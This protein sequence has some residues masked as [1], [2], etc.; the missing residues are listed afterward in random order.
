M[1]LWNKTT[2]PGTTTL[3]TNSAK[4]TEITEIGHGTSHDLTPKSVLDPHSGGWTF[5]VYYQW[6]TFTGLLW[7]TSTGSASRHLASPDWTR[8]RPKLLAKPDVEETRVRYVEQPGVWCCLHRSA[9]VGLQQNLVSLGQ[10]NNI[11]SKADP[12]ESGWMI[13][14]FQDK[15][16]VHYCTYTRPPGWKVLGKKERMR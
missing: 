16:I 13:P 15:H 7:I 9:W 12:S 10:F 6:F 2:A 5:T 4:I 1:S 11:P 3:C 8:R 14:P